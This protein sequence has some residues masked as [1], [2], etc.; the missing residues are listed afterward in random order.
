M[1]HSDSLSGLSLLIAGGGPD[2]FAAIEDAFKAQGGVVFRVDVLEDALDF[3]ER[4]AVDVI[5]ADAGLRFDTTTVEL[6]D[7][8]AASSIVYLATEGSR[9]NSAELF[10]PN[11]ED[12]INTQ[13]DPRRFIQMVEARLVK[14]NSGSTALTVT[15][16]LIN[17][18]RPYFL[19]R[20]P[21][22]RAALE[23]LPVIAASNQTVLIS[24]E[25]G[26]GKEIV[27]RAIH[28][29]SKRAGGPFMAVNC[30]AIPEGLIEGELFGHE[31]GAFTGAAR[32]RKGKFEAA[33]NGTLFLDE[34]GDMPLLLQVRLLRVL[35][36]RHI[37]RVGGER[38]IPINVRVIAATRVGLKQAVADGLFREDLYYR[39]NILRIHLPPLRQRVEDIAYL[40]FHFLGRAFAEMGIQPPYPPLSPAS[41]DLIEG[42]PW[43]GN[44]RELRNVMTRVATLLPRGTKQVLPIHVTPHLEDIEPQPG[45]HVNEQ[46]RQHDRAHSGSL[47]H[48]SGRDAIFIPIGTSL[49]DAEDQIIRET[50]RHTGNNRTKAAKILRIGI[51]TL[52]RK[53][54]ESGQIDL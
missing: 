46:D 2:T 35:E 4:R 48:E 13:I 21:A 34:I 9:P 26:S 39:L 38:P 41:I 51:R 52:R 47:E 49:D 32:T 24:G 11:V 45:E 8:L 33:N 42:L 3:V 30:G 15:D 16:P 27:A 36:E 53:L 7:S 6:I 17:K 50:L 19:F 28:V 22:M 23:N 18:L 10:T 43:R 31:K 14:H 44:V 37:Y 5:L 12:Y 20:S 1:V 29:L 40:A 54:S 25:T